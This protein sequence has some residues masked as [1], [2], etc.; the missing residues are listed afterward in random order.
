MSLG[1]GAGGPSLGERACGIPPV[2]EGMV[3][4]LEWVTAL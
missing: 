4:P 1:L 2:R 3:D